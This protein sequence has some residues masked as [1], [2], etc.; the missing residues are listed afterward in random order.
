ME[1][2]VKDTEKSQE[3]VPTRERG[4]EF[5]PAW[6]RLDVRQQLYSHGGA[7]NRKFCPTRET[8]S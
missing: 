2:A 8:G 7:G 1:H 5:F 3:L 6:R 4:N